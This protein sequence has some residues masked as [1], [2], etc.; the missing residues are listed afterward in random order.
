MLHQMIFMRYPDLT[1]EF[2]ILL[3]IP[4]STTDISKELFK[5]KYYFIITEICYM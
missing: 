2:D 4:D 1:M 3:N 5:L